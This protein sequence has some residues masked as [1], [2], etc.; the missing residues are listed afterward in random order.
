MIF[1][2]AMKREQGT[3]RADLGNRSSLSSGDLAKDAGLSLDTIHHYE[4]I[5]VLPKAARTASGYRQFP[6]EALRRLRLVRTALA[7]GFTLQEIA[8]IVRDRDAG[9]APCQRVLSLA[10]EKLES[11]QKEIDERSRYR[12]ELASVVE[13]WTQILEGIPAGTAGRLLESMT[14]VPPTDQPAGIRRNRFR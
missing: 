3:Q 4:R 6:P 7:L 5:G 1:F 2:A 13:R 9:R 10:R 11:L 14:A 8:S 12:D